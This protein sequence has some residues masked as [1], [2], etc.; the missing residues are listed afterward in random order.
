MTKY[1]GY[2]LGQVIV[3]NLQR[4][5]LLLETIESEL[6][7]SNIKDALLTSAIGSLQ[8]VVLHRVIGTGREPEDEFVTLEKPMELASLQGMVLDGKAHFH[9]VVS[10]VEQSYTGHLEP[11]TTVLYLGEVSLV[12]LK[13]VSL[14]R[15][16]N[17]DNI[18]MIVEVVSSKL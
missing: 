13:G 17:E 11:G 5:D 1:K 14:C 16:K 3:L 12:E 7:K 4:G 18:G 6:K 10:D 8:R 2:E 15:E 9:M